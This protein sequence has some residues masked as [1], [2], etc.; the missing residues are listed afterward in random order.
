VVYIVAEQ[1]LAAFIMLVE[2]TSECY[3]K[4]LVCGTIR[5][6]SVEFRAGIDGDNALALISPVT[7]K[8]WTHCH[9]KLACILLAWEDR[10]S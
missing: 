4:S 9:V 5:M 2:F 1:D 10:I 3:K 8:V 6:P 7:L